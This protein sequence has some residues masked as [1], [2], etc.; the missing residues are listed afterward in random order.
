MLENRETRMIQCRLS[1]AHNIANGPQERS[2]EA[3]ENVILKGLDPKCTQPKQHC[4]RQTTG[5]G[6]HYAVCNLWAINKS[7]PGDMECQMGRHSFPQGLP[8][9][10]AH[11]NCLCELRIRKLT[12]SLL[13]NKTKRAWCKHWTNTAWERSG[14]PWPGTHLSSQ[15]SPRAE[16]VQNPGRISSGC[17]QSLLPFYLRRLP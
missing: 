2:A 13:K 7:A 6:E 9:T 11:A 17:G 1:R 15:A 14:S 10:M 5:A 16:Q 8:V 12:V 4:S 3:G